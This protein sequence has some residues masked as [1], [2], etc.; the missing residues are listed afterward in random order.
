MPSM[1]YGQMP[2]RSAFDRAFD[3]E[4]PDGD[5]AFGNDERFGTTEV[6]R[7]AVWDELHAALAEFEEGEHSD[8]CPGDGECEGRPECKGEAAGQWCSCVLGVLGFEWI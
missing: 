2:T 3:R 4:C 1:T 5:F 6:G 7:E 8:E